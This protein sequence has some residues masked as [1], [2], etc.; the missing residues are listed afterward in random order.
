MMGRDHALLGAVVFLAAAPTVAV[1][2]HYDLPIGELAVGSIVTAGFALFPDIDEP[3]S[4]V[5][6]KLGFVSRAVAE[7]TNKLAG[8]HRQATHSALFALFVTIGCWFAVRQNEWVA[9]G[10]VAATV[11]LTAKIILPMGMGRSTLVVMALALGGSYWAMR[12]TGVGMWLPLCAG[13]G[14]MLHLV[15]DMLTIEGVPLFWPLKIR[16]K[17]PI[18][19]HT[20]STREAILG[21]CLSVILLFLV[22]ISILQTLIAHSGNFNFSVGGHNFNV[23]NINTPNITIPGAG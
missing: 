12:A 3:H 19:G 22:Y 23:P 14:C 7:V 1:A 13:I 16:L 20:Q 4:L 10:I 9:F 6:R 15:G 11:L 18:L 5:S 2:A 17:A 8:G 21:F